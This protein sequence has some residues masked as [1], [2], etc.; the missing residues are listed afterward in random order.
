MIRHNVQGSTYDHPSEYKTIPQRNKELSIVNVWELATVPN[1]SSDPNTWHS[2][3]TDQPYVSPSSSS[4]SPLSSSSSSSSFSSSSSSSTPVRTVADPFSID[5]MFQCECGA[6]FE[7]SRSCLHI[8]PRLTGDLRTQVV[9]NLDLVQ[10]LPRCP[11]R[12][13]GSKQSSRAEHVVKLATVTPIT[14]IVHRLPAIVCLDFTP[15]GLVQNDDVDR[16]LQPSFPVSATD[17]AAGFVITNNEPHI[18]GKQY[19]S[20]SSSDNGRGSENVNVR[21]V[22]IGFIYHVK[23]AKVANRSE[24]E[25][26]QQ[27][28]EEKEEEGGEENMETKEEEPQ[29]KKKP[30]AVQTEK[31]ERQKKKKKAPDHYVGDIRCEYD[32]SWQQYD[33]LD[34]DDEDDTSINEPSFVHATPQSDRYLNKVAFAFYGL[35]HTP[36]L[37]ATTT[38]SS[39]HTALP[40][41][42]HNPH[43]PTVPLSSSSLSPTYQMNSLRTP[44]P[45]L[46]LSL[47]APTTATPPSKHRSIHNNPPPHSSSSSSSSWNQH[48]PQPSTQSF[49]MVQP[50]HQ[51]PPS[52]QH[53]KRKRGNGGGGNS[54]GKES[55]PVHSKTTLHEIA[56]WF[57]DCGRRLANDSQA[58]SMRYSMVSLFADSLQ[59]KDERLKQLERENAD[60]HSQ[61]DRF[62]PLEEELRSRLQ[63]TTFDLDRLQ[64]ALAHSQNETRLLKDQTILYRT[65][66]QTVLNAQ[67]INAERV[68]AERDSTISEMQE[69]IDSL[70]P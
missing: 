38:T 46:P 10:P 54:D 35:V 67:K 56:Q 65:E 62:R 1:G 33:D 42:L 37:I 22:P 66:C 45:P 70:P 13:A 16:S 48:P 6:V 58:I 21:Y 49:S 4:S 55:E 52:Y 31:T 69:Y 34:T 68:V 64:S 24:S 51:S 7:H 57:A 44:P 19:S 53:H 27:E 60:L 63:Q 17:L 8:Q 3:P 43:P 36:P 59:Q 12:L 28:G 30:R 2:Q 32:F 25:Q 47:P 18:S 5:S 9:A 11:N 15:F 26:Q 41:P 39:P 50:Q 14:P 40:L 61:A 23:P 20:S 29:E